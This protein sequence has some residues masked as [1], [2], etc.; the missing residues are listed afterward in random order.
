MPSMSPSGDEELTRVAFDED[1]TYKETRSSFEAAFER[2]YVR[3]LL[4][5]HGGN[6]SAAARAARMDRNHLTDLARRHGLDRRR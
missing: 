2:R 1:A 4:D 3:W 6:I 5:R